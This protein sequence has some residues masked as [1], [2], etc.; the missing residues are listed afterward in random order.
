ML[1][2]SVQFYFEHFLIAYYHCLL[3]V[4]TAEFGAVAKL[5]ADPLVFDLAD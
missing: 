1:L 4:L 3:V 2:D 5:L